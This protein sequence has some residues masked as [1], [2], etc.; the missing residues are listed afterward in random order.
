VT[1]ARRNLAW[2][3]GAAGPLAW[4]AST[5]VN[6]AFAAWPCAA[7]A[8]L[9]AAIALALAVIA[10]GGAA[11]SWRGLKRVASA[12]GS[13][14]RKPRSER[15]VA[16]AGMGLALLFALVIAMQG[17]AGLIFDGCEL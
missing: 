1:G 4:L 13:L 7:R 14:P 5:Q 12:P 16:A 15:F 11:L 2:A 8:P 10:L 9:V 17:T 6:Y 3:G